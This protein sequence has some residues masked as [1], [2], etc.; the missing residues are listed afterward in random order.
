[1]LQNNMCNSLIIY[2]KYKNFV[3]HFSFINSLENTNVVDGFVNKLREF[4]DLIFLYEQNVIKIMFKEVYK[5]LNLLF[6]PRRAM[7]E[8]FNQHHQYNF[9][10]TQKECECYGLLV[11]GQSAKQIASNLSLCVSTVEFHIKNIKKK[12][13]VCSKYD[14]VSHENRITIK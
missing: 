10:L 8:V 14:F 13:G 4:E 11:R 5:P 3:A 9:V 7:S 6:L 1:M 12:L 2:K